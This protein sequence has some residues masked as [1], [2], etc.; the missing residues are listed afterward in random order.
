MVPSKNLQLSLKSVY[1]NHQYT[2]V[3]RQLLCILYQPPRLCEFQSSWYIVSY[4]D[5][6]YTWWSNAVVIIDTSQ[7][8]REDISSDIKANIHYT[9]TITVITAS[10]NLTSNAT[11]SKSPPYTH[12]SS[13]QLIII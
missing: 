2:V 3:A 9:I 8:I 5:G 7:L 1:Y 10:G 13:Y 11:I 12:H 6:N 4:T